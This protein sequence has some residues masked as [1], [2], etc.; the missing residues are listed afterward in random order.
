LRRRAGDE[1]LL[2]CRSYRR[3]AGDEVLLDRR[4]QKFIG[5]GA[6]GGICGCY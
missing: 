4:L 1:V 6:F 2:D 3:R 5:E